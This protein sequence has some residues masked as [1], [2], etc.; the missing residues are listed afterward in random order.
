MKFFMADF[1][2]TGL[3]TREYVNTLI[4]KRNPEIH[5]GRLGHVLIVAGSLG[6]AGAAMLCTKGALR[7]GCGLATIATLE[8][9]FPILQVGIPE[10]MCI[11]REKE[12]DLSKYNVIAAG[13]GLGKDE[14]NVYL[15]KR[16]LKEFTGTVVLD[17]DGLNL[18]ANYQL[19][20]NLQESETRLII[21]PHPG[22]A[23]RLLHI[24]P[25]EINEVRL[26]NCVRLAEQT[27]AVAVLKGAGTVVATPEGKTYINTT[28]NPGM[29]T[30][31]SGDVLTG[32]IASLAAQGLEPLDAAKAGVYL[33]GYAGDKA[34]G[35]YGEYGMIAGDIADQIAFAIKDVCNI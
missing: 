1:A 34:A 20:K 7:T 2:K 17:A 28:G 16:I 5:K 11:S 35:I 12:F 6:M 31:G 33:H 23:A 27:R 22:E 8:E 14:K 13:P 10:A 19:I 25:S 18:I 30:G 3:I 26:K 9:L 15:I 32:V 21:T 24:K 4:K 29:A